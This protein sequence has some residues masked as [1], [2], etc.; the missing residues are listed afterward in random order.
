M[1]YLAFA[2]NVLVLAAFTIELHQARKERQSLSLLIKSKDV[3]EFV[4]AE[5]R[6]ASPDPV[7]KPDVTPPVDLEEADPEEVLDSLKP[8]A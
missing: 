6:L 4:R 3:A 5:R 7:D 1:L 8:K 2:F